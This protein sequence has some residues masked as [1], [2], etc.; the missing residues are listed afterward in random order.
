M[1]NSSEPLPPLSFL[2][3][4]GVALGEPF[5][6]A[7]NRGA[8]LSRYMGCQNGVPVFVQIPRPEQRERFVAEYHLRSFLHAQGVSTPAM[9]L[10]DEKSGTVVEQYRAPL[11]AAGDMVVELGYTGP[12]TL[13]I[14]LKQNVHDDGVVLPAMRAAKRLLHECRGALTLY[15]DKTG[16]EP[17]QSYGFFEAIAGELQRGGEASAAKTALACMALLR[18]SGTYEIIKGDS[19]AGNFLLEM[20]GETL[21]LIDFEEAGLGYR[22]QDE[23]RLLFTSG[24]CLPKETVLSLAGE[25]GLL[26]EPAGA[27]QLALLCAFRH[28][29]AQRGGY[30]QR[31]E[32]YAGIL[33]ELYEHALH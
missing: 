8:L 23:A 26:A 13:Y 14:R 2:A 25:W 30:E 33:K 21:L 11:A 18:A 17:V 29:Q 9:L 16:G 15:F 5:Y 1:A 22:R 12:M 3:K 24:L 20:P 27:A 19:G 32:Q 4:H 31:A 10:L 6:Q 28:M 7:G